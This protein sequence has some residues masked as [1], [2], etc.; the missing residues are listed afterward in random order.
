[1]RI[2][3]DAMVRDQGTKTIQDLG[4]RVHAV[5]CCGFADRTADVVGPEIDLVVLDMGNA[6]ANGHRPLPRLKKTNGW[7]KVLTSGFYDFPP[8]SDLLREL[9]FEFKAF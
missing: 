1:M 5:P 6:A 9:G 7:S 8:A 2:E 3:A 4:Y